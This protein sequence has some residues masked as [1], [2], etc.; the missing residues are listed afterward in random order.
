MALQAGDKYL[1]IS[2][3]GGEIKLVAFHNKDKTLPEQPDYKGYG[4]AVWIC[5][6][7]GDEPIV[8]EETIT[9][10]KTI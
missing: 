2:L 7:K 10:A 8:S 1:R 4:T 9:L 6:K 5:E 3:L